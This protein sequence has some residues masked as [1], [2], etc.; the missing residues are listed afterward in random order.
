MSIFNINEQIIGLACSLKE[1]VT[2]YR[3]GK[4]NTA[5][6]ET[7]I[8]ELILESCQHNPWFIADHVVYALELLAEDL[9]KIAEDQQSIHNGNE[10]R[11]AVLFRS[12]APLEG[13]AE[14]FQLVKYG[15]ACEVKP[16]SDQQ[17]ILKKFL[18]YLNNFPALAGT[19]K[20]NNHKFTDFSALI[21]L[22]ELGATTIDYFNKYQSLQLHRKGI[23]CILNGNEDNSLKD[24]ITE[25]VCMYYGRSTQNIKVLFVPHDYNINLLTPAL[26][27]YA[28]QLFHNRYYNNFE[29]RK[30]AMIINHISFNETGPLLVTES[31]SQAG[32]TGVLCIQR[33]SSANDI[34]N[35]ELSLM[36]K[37]LN[38][39]DGFDNIPSL[40]LSTLT[41]NYEKLNNFFQYISTQNHQF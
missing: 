12:Y 11:V 3:S 16:S 14:L 35:N 20:E 34:M 18:L 24:K 23:S 40:S 39:L 1:S 5:S 10:K 4:T 19:I 33:Y 26:E 28:D 30:S 17:Y 8:H 22:S 29:Y 38:S 9:V 32:Y 6:S 7:I 13:V 15:Y 2:N 31:A 36:Y 25:M 27:L 21:S 41:H 37:P